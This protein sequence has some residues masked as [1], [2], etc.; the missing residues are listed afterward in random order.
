MMR[1]FKPRKLDCGDI[2]KETEEKLI[3]YFSEEK[4]YSDT[5]IRENLAPCIDLFEKLLQEGVEKNE[6]I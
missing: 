2:W 1:I 6:K 3:K 4:G 5:Y